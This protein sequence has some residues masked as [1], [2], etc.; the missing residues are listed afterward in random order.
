MSVESLILDANWAIFLIHG[1]L[2]PL[3]Q[4]IGTARHEYMHALFGTIQGLDIHEIRI[5]PSRIDGK[6]YWGYIRWSGGE[7]GAL[8]YTAPYIADAILLVL[9]SLVLKT[10]VNVDWWESHVH[11]LFATAIILLVSPAV[12][13]VYNMFKWWIWGLGDFARAFGSD[14]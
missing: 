13:I 9:A 11:T 14:D 7:G 2:Y 6:W 3:Y 8:F 1:L 4:V 10:W 5:L 12:D